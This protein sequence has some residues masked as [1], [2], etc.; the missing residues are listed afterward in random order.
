MQSNLI[1]YCIDV[2]QM[3]IL[4]QAAMLPEFLSLFHTQKSLAQIH[5]YQLMMHLHV[6]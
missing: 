2:Q 1:H 3:N 5:S 4:Y 6:M